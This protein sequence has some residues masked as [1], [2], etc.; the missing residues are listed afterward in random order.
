MIWG[1]LVAQMVNNPP[2]MQETWVRSL[3]WED[4]LEKG[5]VTHAIILGVA[6]FSIIH[7]VTK[8]QPQLSKFHSLT[9]RYEKV[10][11]PFV[12]SQLVSMGSLQPTPHPTSKPCFSLFQQGWVRSSLLSPLLK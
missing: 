9:W 12:L 10:Y 2:E 3:S 4:P 8:S 1:F 7:G 6:L 11:F 5:K